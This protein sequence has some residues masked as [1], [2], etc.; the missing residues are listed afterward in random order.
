MTMKTSEKKSENTIR[1]L[2]R[3]R[4]KATVPKTYLEVIEFPVSDSER[5][6]SNCRRLLSTNHTPSKSDFA[7][8]VPSC[9]TTV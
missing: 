1:K 9:R 3:I 4:D 5:G 2:A 7:M 6:V 8:R